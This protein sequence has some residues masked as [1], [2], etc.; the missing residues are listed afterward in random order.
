M[1]LAMAVVSALALS[2]C[3]S[4]HVMGTRPHSPVVRLESLPRGTGW[5]NEPQPTSVACT[6]TDSCIVWGTDGSTSPNCI[7]PPRGSSVGFWSDSGGPWH[8]VSMPDGSC[9]DLTT[10]GCGPSFCLLAGTTDARDAVWRFDARAHTVQ[11]LQPPPGG[12][13]VDEVS[14]TRTGAC[15]MA[16]VARNRIRF[17]V[18]DDR[19][20]K[21]RPDEALNGVDSS[22]GDWMSGL[23][24][25]STSNCIVAVSRAGELSDSGS[26]TVWLTSTSGVLARRDFPQPSLAELWCASARSCSLATADDDYA[27]FWLQEHLYTSSNGGRTWNREASAFGKSMMLTGGAGG[28]VQSQVDFA[29]GGDRCVGVG[30]ERGSSGTTLFLD[31]GRWD[32][33]PIVTRPDWGFSAV[34]CGRSR[35]VSVGGLSPPDSPWYV[36]SFAP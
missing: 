7:L 35:C 12:I 33:N 14:C 24:C 5:Q 31:E 26:T 1:V 23:W 21:W 29:C 15:V 11:V 8:G 6:L 13:A 18:S 22:V 28:V 17:L 4:P 10:F 3:S 2:G 34:S 19:G 25:W 30:D 27:G 32:W 20:A 36:A 9:A 16:D